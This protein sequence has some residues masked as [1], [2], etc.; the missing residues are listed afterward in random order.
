M[1]TGDGALELAPLRGLRYAGADASAL[2]DSPAFNLALALSPPYDLVDAASYA[3]MTTDEPHNAARLT[4]P[5]AVSAPD[6]TGAART[7]HRW[8]EEGVLVRDPSPAVYAYE[9]TTPEGLRQRGLIGLLRLPPPGGR[10]V[11]PHESIAEEPVLDRARLMAATRANLE[12][13][14]LLYRGGHGAERGAASRAADAPAEQGDEPLVHTVTGDGVTHRLWALTDA[15]LHARI[16]HDLAGR[17]ALIADGHHRYA[18]YR[19]LQARQHGPGPWDLGLAL[20]VDSDA[21]PPRLGPIHRVVPGIGARA[22]ADAA[23]AH[24]RVRALPEDGG[25]DRT[26]RL[27]AQA[28]RQG[29][30]LALADHSGRFLIDR[31]DPGAMRAAAPDRSEAWRAM[32]TA[33]L[34]RLFLPL[35]GVRPR[36]AE[37]VHD[38]AAEAVRRAGARTG[39][40]AAVL[41]PPLRVAD[42]YEVTGRGELTPRKSTSFG[43]KPRTG[44]V[45]RSLESL[46]ERTDEAR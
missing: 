7:L 29:P 17:T 21:S 10:A 22:A 41:L 6:Y 18:A 19:R 3:R 2:I 14:F 27:L 11:R 9:Q 12:P 36:A 39:P 45:L 26:V 13:I 33:A 5:P 25:T 30:A 31:V 8:I 4:A 16:A 40:A 32:P 20:L 44:L 23:R 24:A 37:L 35:W 43:P 1:D 46:P 42:V 28:A 15:G 38:D 34:E